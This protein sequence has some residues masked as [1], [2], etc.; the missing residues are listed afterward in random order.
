MMVFRLCDILPDVIKVKGYSVVVV[1]SGKKAG[2]VLER[3]KFSPIFLD[4]NILSDGN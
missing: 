2:E 1:K 3:R 4:S